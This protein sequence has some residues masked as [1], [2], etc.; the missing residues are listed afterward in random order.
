MN[1][2]DGETCDALAS[3]MRRSGR[4]WRRALNEAL[5]AQGLTLLQWAVLELA[6]GQPGMSQVEL[7]RAVGV[8]GPSLVRV[9]DGLQKDGWLRREVDAHDRRVNRVYP[10]PKAK[11]RMRRAQAAVDSVQRRAVSRMNETDRKEFVRMVEQVIEG[12]SCAPRPQ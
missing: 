1:D 5:E 3:A 8:G 2:A 6:W 12:L 11:G 7:A 9:L 4:V 10:L